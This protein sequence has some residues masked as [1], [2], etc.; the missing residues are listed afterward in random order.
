MEVGSSG[1]WRKKEWEKKEEEA[2][3][4]DL[5]SAESR[6][7]AWRDSVAPMHVARLSLATLGSLAR[8]CQGGSSVAPKH[9]A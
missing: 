3:R 4:A 9:V 8:V 5:Y 1:E 2:V 6:H 7:A